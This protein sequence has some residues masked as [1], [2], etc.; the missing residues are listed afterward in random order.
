MG[1]GTIRKCGLVR[2]G[3]VLLGEVYHWGMG[4]GILDAQARPSVS[5][6]FLLS[7]NLNLEPSISMSAYIPPCFLS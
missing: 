3:V 5:H 6:V 4:F 1:S 7:A 2:V